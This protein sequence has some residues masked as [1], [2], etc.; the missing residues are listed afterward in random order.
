MGVL[1]ESRLGSI[2]KGSLKDELPKEDLERAT[3]ILLR[4]VS[5]S[6][7]ATLLLPNLD[8]PYWTSFYSLKRTFLRTFL[9]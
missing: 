4:V 3:A 2:K 6:R 5:F 7:D 1:E 8:R 9:R